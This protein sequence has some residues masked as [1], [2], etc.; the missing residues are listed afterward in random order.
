MSHGGEIK[1]FLVM[2]RTLS[3]SP[4]NKNVYEYLKY[5]L[6]WLIMGIVLI[7]NV[8]TIF[9]FILEFVLVWWGKICCTT[10]NDPF[11][12]CYIIPWM[13]SRQKFCMLK[14]FQ[15]VWWRFFL[16]GCFKFHKKPWRVLIISWLYS[17]NHQWANEIEFINASDKV[18]KLLNE[19]ILVNT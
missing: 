17:L 12:G 7:F 5:R 6:I 1:F 15:Q 3:P 16:I 2:G 10:N 19:W 11:A 13:M 9:V 8:I 18:R 4:L 14:I